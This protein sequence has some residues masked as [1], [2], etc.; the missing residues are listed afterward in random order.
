MVDTASI[1]AKIETKIFVNLG[2]TAIWTSIIEGSNTK[3]GDRSDTY[4]TSSSITIVPW[5]HIYAKE[6]FFD[7]GDLE[8]GEVDVALRYT[9]PLTINDKLL[10][11][12]KI[13]KVKA[14]QYYT[15]KDALLVKV[16]RLTETLLP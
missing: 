3:W 13:Y 4:A 11:N 9:Q 10:W 8:S 15:L 12:T 5:G 6:D 1:I 16:A 2:S 7:F 14:I